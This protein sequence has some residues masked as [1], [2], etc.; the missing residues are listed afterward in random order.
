MQA[1]AQ[2]W[3][4]FSRLPGTQD[5]AAAARLA[6]H[7]G[8]L[9]IRDRGA[10]R[11]HDAR[12]VRLDI[13]QVAQPGR[14]TRPVGHEIDR[15]PG[16]PGGFAV[17]L[18][19]NRG[20][21]G[22]AHPDIEPATGHPRP[23]HAVGRETQPRHAFGIGLHVRLAHQPALHAQRA[24]MVAQRH[25]AHFQ[26]KVVPGRTMGMHMAPGV[27]AHP[28]GAADR[29]LHIGAPATPRASPS[30]TAPR[31]ARRPDCA[32]WKMQWRQRTARS[33]AARAGGRP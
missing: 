8:D 16:Q 7:G 26:R 1:R 18:M 22:I 27:K 11:R 4:Q 13:G 14:A 19:D 21:P 32:R 9:G 3:R 2:V 17:G 28:A 10:V 20:Q 24:Q 5:D 30:P 25:L 33:A 12:P 6:A 23:D 15:L 31:A 29:R